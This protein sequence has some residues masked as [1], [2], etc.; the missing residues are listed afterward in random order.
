VTT[1]FCNSHAGHKIAE[2][3]MR[4]ID[5]VIGRRLRLRRRK[6]RLS[7]LAWSGNHGTTRRRRRAAR[8]AGHRR[9]RTATKRSSP[10]AHPLAVATLSPVVGDPVPCRPRHRETI[11]SLLLARSVHRIMAGTNSAYRRTSCR[12]P[13]SGKHRR[14]R[15]RS[16]PDFR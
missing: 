2:R 4:T 14:R 10:D 1:L 16:L 12:S 11:A 6:P 8:P 3:I 13:K 7:A 9:G 5:P 15:R